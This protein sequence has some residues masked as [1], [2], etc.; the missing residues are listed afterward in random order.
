MATPLYRHRAP[1]REL[2]S[3]YRFHLSR[4][5]YRTSA[6]VSI[7]AFFA[8]VV[9]SF[10]AIAYATER[11]S[12]SVTDI[13]LSNI[14]AFDVDALFAVGTILLIAFIVALVLAHPKRLPYVLNSLTV[15]FLIRSVFITLT[16]IGP[17]PLT[18][19]PSTD[20]G[21]LLNHFL[22]S[23]DLF[24]SAH[25]GVPFLMALI[26]WKEKSLR[27]IFLGWSVYMAV[28]VL[29]GHYH[30][31]IDV[32]SAYFITYT[33]FCIVEWLFPKDRALFYSDAPVSAI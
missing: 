12:S 1:H 4:S 33:I 24:F 27:Y 25:T 22:F 14:P 9:V 15:F 13:I 20:W 30:Y 6:L 23:S 3:R 32:A 8:S 7:V 10:Y 31:S 26:F 28:V 18:A 21:T 19:E 17:F 5:E 11:A 16:H 29:L 2:L